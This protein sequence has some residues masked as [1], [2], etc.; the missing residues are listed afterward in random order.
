MRVVRANG[1]NVAYETTGNP[2]HPTILLP[3]RNRSIRM[4]RWNSV[5]GSVTSLP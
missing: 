4:L 1:I 3:H 2:D 5:S